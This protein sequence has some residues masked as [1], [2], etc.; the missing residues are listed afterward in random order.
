M[1]TDFLG[2][3]VSLNPRPARQRRAALEEAMLGHSPGRVRVARLL[4]LPDLI[5]EIRGLGYGRRLDA[6]ARGEADT[7]AHLPLPLHSVAEFDDIFPEARRASTRY[8]SVLAGDRA[9]LPWAVEDF[10]ANGGEKLW[11]IVVPEEE[12]ADGFMPN[13]GV[14]PLEVDNLRGLG[15]LA[16][17]ERVGL[18]ALPD[19]ERLQIPAGLQDIPRKR[20]RNPTPQFLP[21]TVNTDDDHRER[22]YS[23]ELPVPVAPLPLVQLLRRFLPLLEK[24]RGEAQCLFTLPLDHSP[25]LDSP[26]LHPQEREA[27]DVAARAVDGYRLRQVQFVFPYLRS[28]KRKLATP[29]GLLAGLMAESA[30]RRGVW[31]SVAGLPMIGDGHPYPPLTLADTLELRQRP[32]IGIVQARSGRLMLDDER[33]TVPALA[34]GDYDSRNIGSPALDGYRSGEVARFIG[35]L[36]RELRELGESLV[37]NVGAQDPR[38]RLVLEKF[39]TDLH[40]SGALRGA[41]PEQA[42]TIRQLN[43]PDSVIA[44]E[45]EVAP[46]FPIDRLVLTFVNR[47]AEWSA[48]VRGG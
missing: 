10:F 2:A 14:S 32:G 20:L 46:A 4:Q 31:R 45:I 30:R 35:Y 25:L 36:R 18:F 8:Q 22:R 44:F 1:T 34:R 39:F 26:V 21:C 38:P 19:L 5:G 37:F 9:W 12:G 13:P 3:R 28:A 16:I 43:A 47:D 7:L 40:R 24:Q 48:E 15:L 42:F 11:V 17:L 41:L 33:L 27:L 23:E 29:V 6:M